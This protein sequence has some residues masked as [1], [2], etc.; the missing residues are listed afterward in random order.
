MMSIAPSGL[1]SCPSSAS[2]NGSIS[3]AQM[4]ARSFVKRLGSSSILRPRTATSPSANPT[5]TMLAPSIAPYPTLSDPEM[6][7]DTELIISGADAAIAT[8]TVPI[9]ASDSPSFFA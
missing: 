1:L 5:W 6:N 8:T 2:M 4:V 9:M 3:A 7:P